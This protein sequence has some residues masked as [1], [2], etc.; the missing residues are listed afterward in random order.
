[1][2]SVCGYLIVVMLALSH[3][4]G[5]PQ[6]EDLHHPNEKTVATNGGNTKDGKEKYRDEKESTPFTLLFILSNCADSISHSSTRS[7][8]LI[9]LKGKVLT[10][11]LKG[12]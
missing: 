4:A 10:N 3:M 8:L 6:E 11:V 5:R 7:T 1:M 12:S 2:Y 9:E